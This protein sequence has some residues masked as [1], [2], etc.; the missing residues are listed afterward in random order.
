GRFFTGLVVDRV[1]AALVAATTF[2]ASRVAL[3]YLGALPPS[4]TLLGLL[5]VFFVGLASGSES[6]LLA[7]MTRRYFGDREYGAIYNRILSIHFIGPVLGPF[8][9]GVFFDRLGGYHVILIAFGVACLIGAGLMLC[10]GPYRYGQD[11]TPGLK[12]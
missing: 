4:P 7:F 12:D 1:H 9:M 5:P 8:S 2:V 3:F 10:L 11:D 6:D